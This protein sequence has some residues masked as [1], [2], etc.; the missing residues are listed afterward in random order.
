MDAQLIQA[1]GAMTVAE[2]Q[3]KRYATMTEEEKKEKNRK[4]TEAARLRREK[5]RARPVVDEGEEKADLP[6]LARLQTIELNGKD[7][8]I[9][10]VTRGL[11]SKTGV[12]VDDEEN[13]VEERRRV[14]GYDVGMG[15]RNKVGSVRFKWRGRNV[16]FADNM[17]QNFYDA[18]TNER[19]GNLGVWS[20]GETDNLMYPDPSRPEEM[21]LWAFLLNTY[22]G[23]DRTLTKKDLDEETAKLTAETLEVAETKRARE[24][25]ERQEQEEKARKVREA[26]EEKRRLRREMDERSAMEGEDPYALRQESALAE[27]YGS[28]F[29]SLLTIPRASVWRADR[30]KA[31]SGHSLR[32][33]AREMGLALPTNEFTG[34]LPDAVYTPLRNYINGMS[35]AEYA[36]R[37][38]EA[39]IRAFLRPLVADE[40]PRKEAR[41]QAAL[42]EKAAKQAAEDAYRDS[43][44]NDDWGF[45]PTF[46]KYFNEIAKE[47]G[48]PTPTK[49]TMKEMV[50]YARSF[51]QLKWGLLP[52]KDHYRAF[53]SQKSK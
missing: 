53:F 32:A 9:D 14:L 43:L 10:P 51:S 37:P 48:H 24:E 22:S 49:E 16:V 1:M 33:Y 4:K 28:L 31:L 30:M 23:P 34:S 39:H 38:L 6:V 29:P 19:L 18:K 52:L 20:L 3:R 46:R 41:K 5:E 45:N 27:T 42:A 44:P 17:G 13:E 25:R 12:K 26:E 15:T 35:D 8:L 11:Y 36:S 2:R 40:A 21:R 50:A 7:Y 47:M